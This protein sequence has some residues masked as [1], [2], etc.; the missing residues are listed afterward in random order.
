M[1]CGA[2]EINWE[3]VLLAGGQLEKEL[4]PLG[5]FPS[6]AY[7]PLQGKPLAEYPLHAIR[8]ISKFKRIVTILPEGGSPFPGTISAPGGNTIIQSM[9]AAMSVILPET[10][11]VLFVTC[12]LP[13]LTKESLIDFMGQCQNADAGLY[14]SFVSQSDSE[15]KFPNAPHTYATL[16]GNKFCGGGLIGIAPK[17]FSALV[18]LADKATRNR[19]NVLAIVN[20]LGFSI[21]IKFLLKKLSIS[22]IEKRAA[23]LLGFPVK[24]I[25]S[26]F[27]EIALNIDDLESFTLA[28]NILERTR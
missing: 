20:L 9:S 11:R 16:G 22:D 3:A 24:G 21:A 14:Y 28:Q 5:S 1:G 18:L 17:N 27:P 19:K 7:L 10:N 25:Q 15:M 2:V 4:A 12:D 26:H 8:S 13:F 6:K 23:Q